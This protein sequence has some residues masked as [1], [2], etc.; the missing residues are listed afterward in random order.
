[1]LSINFNNIKDLT[2]HLFI[3]NTFDEFY[4]IEAN[5][6]TNI[7]YSIDG[8]LNKEFFNEDEVPLGNFNKYSS[9]KNVL[10]NIIKGKHLP[11]NFKVILGIFPEDINICS[12]DINYFC[13]TFKYENRQMLLTLAPSYNKFTL[14]KSIEATFEK[15]ISD[16]LDK[17]HLDYTIL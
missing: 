7:S 17:Y 4:F 13:L 6:K 8:H 11:I 1:M 3:N 5:L 14:D 10:Y 9:I 15:Y 16:F 2:Q 12:E